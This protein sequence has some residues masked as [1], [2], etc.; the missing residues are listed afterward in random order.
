MFLTATATGTCSVRAVKNGGANYLDETTTATIYWIPFL[1]NY[2]TG[3]STSGTG[4]ALTGETSVVKRTYDTFTVASFADETGT[5]VTS[6]KANT[7]LRVIGTGFVADDATT[8]VF[9]G[10]ESVSHSGLTFNVLDP[11]ANYVLLTIPTDAET[12]RVVMRSAKGWATSP[13]TLT[14]TP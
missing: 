2:Q 3:V 7:K 5:A 1:T 10:I 14:I 11:L 13:G 4:I 6:I 8:Q 12:D 9:F